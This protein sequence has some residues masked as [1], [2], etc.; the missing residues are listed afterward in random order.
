MSERNRRS[1]SFALS[2]VLSVVFLLTG[3]HSLSW[4]GK[5]AG[6]GTSKTLEFNPP[7]ASTVLQ[8]SEWAQFAV[9]VLKSDGSL[10][11]K[12]SK[13]RINLS[14]TSGATGTLSGTLTKTVAAGVA[15]FTGISYNQTGTI[16]L[17]ATASDIAGYSKLS[18]P[19][20]VLPPFA[21]SQVAPA[22]GAVNVPTSSAIS[23]TFN[24]DVLALSINTSTF[25]ISPSVP[26]NYTVSGST[27]TFTPTSKLGYGTTYTATLTQGAMDSYGNQ[28]AAAKT[29]SFTT[30]PAPLAW[31]QFNP[32]LAT[33][34]LQNAVWPQF[35]VRALRSDG[36]LDSSNNSTQITVSINVGI[37]SALTGT[38][39]KTVTAG[40]AT[41]T[42]IAYSL[43]GNVGLKA[44]S[45]SLPGYTALS[46]NIVV[47]AP[48][49]V[50]S[51]APA[52]NAT[53]VS[54]TTAISCTFNWAVKAS[55][56]NS[57][58]FFTNPY[59]PGTY[60]VSGYTAT[61]TPSAPLPYG[62]TYA[63]TLTQA[64][65]DTAGVPLSAPYAWSF[66]TTFPPDWGIP[67]VI[68]T[69]TGN[70]NVSFAGDTF[71]NGLAA[72]QKSGIFLYSNR[73]ASGQWGGEQLLA[74]ATTYI[75]PPQVAVGPD[76]TL[77]VWPDGN[78]PVSMFA[79]EFQE[80]GGWSQTQNL[81]LAQNYPPPSIAAGTNQATAVWLSNSIV[82]AGRWDAAMNSFGTAA[83]IS[84]TVSPIVP[85]QFPAVC[86][87]RSGASAVAIW[88]ES[89][90]G[91]LSLV[92]N[93]F[94]GNSWGTP[95]VIASPVA[96][97]SSGSGIVCDAAGNTTVSWHATVGSPVT[98][99]VPYTIRYEATPPLYPTANWMPGWQAPVQIGPPIG[100]TWS[101]SAI[102][103]AADASGAVI[104]VWP[105]IY[106]SVQGGALLTNRYDPATG[107]G[108]LESVE[109]I[110]ASNAVHRSIAVAVDKGT[111]NG[112]AAAFWVDVATYRMYASIL[113]TPSGTWGPAETVSEPSTYMPPQVSVD[114]NGTVR[115][116]WAQNNSILSS[117]RP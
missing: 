41:F 83:A 109:T 112:R 85:P 26:G 72:W 18:N 91:T 36:S 82:Y 11:V 57:S 13:T 75:Y 66:T 114:S 45:P 9:R 61:F 29:W 49:A 35:A 102:S 106:G 89:N 64:V 46:N 60:N 97:T 10:D 104:A 54:R 78:G 37:S 92:A 31:L 59:V 77:A 25:L 67:E 2:L 19:V 27:A 88:K 58:T 7:P 108:S 43:T 87:D 84:N 100:G 71:G 105:A 15:T 90:A 42:D 50:N 55:T 1:M 65:T 80:P 99:L 62:A 5:P 117:V 115:A 32:P 51:V 48:F 40:V 6:G 74:Q 103:L 95:T 116:V 44:T 28:L 16:T 23:V 63:V 56:I 93:R 14:L 76:P 3:M 68:S 79:S 73:L 22:E 110:H 101:E 30:A 107:W 12:N 39:T 81:G 34:V 69:G 33:P 53:N 70:N 4:A 111:S 47:N 8:N 52:P 20:T 94:D 17:K 86:Q 98:N 21:V 113:D 38:L 24:R 96:L